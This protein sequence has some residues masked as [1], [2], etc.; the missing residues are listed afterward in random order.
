MDTKEKGGALATEFEIRPNNPN[1]LRKTYYLQFE[2]TLKKKG[3]TY[4]FRGA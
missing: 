2:V 3:E 4:F 1:Y